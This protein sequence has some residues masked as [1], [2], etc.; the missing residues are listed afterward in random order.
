MFLYVIHMRFSRRRCLLAAAAL[1]LV[2]GMSLLLAGCFDGAHQE[3]TMLS[4]N[5]QRV[6]YLQELGWQVSPEP[7]ETLDLQLPEDWRP[8]GA[9]I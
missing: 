9:N 4:T 6:A 3:E 8:N 1:L 7:I 2:T 5:E